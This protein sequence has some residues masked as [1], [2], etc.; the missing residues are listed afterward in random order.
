MVT[1][2]IIQSFSKARS[3]VG[4]LFLPLSQLLLHRALFYGQAEGE[5]EEQGEREVYKVKRSLNH[6]P[7]AFEH[8]IP[9]ACSAQVPLCPRTVSDWC[10]D[11]DHSRLNNTV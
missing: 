2:D 9:V 3:I 5:G 8:F 6:V 10:S 1:L 7:L 4:L 11:P